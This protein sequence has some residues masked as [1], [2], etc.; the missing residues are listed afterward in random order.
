[1]PFVAVAED[2]RKYISYQLQP[3]QERQIWLCPHCGSRM[4]FVST[5]IRIKHFRHRTQS[6]ICASYEPETK[7]H[8]ELKKFGYEKFKSLGYSCNYEE[9]IG[10]RIADVTIKKGITLPIECQFSPL[11]VQEV[12][13]KVEDYEIA[14]VAR[15]LYILYAG[16]NFLRKEE[17]LKRVYRLRRVEVE[18]EGK[19]WWIYYDNHILRE[20]H[21]MPK[22]RRGYKDEWEEVD[23]FCSTLFLIKRSK[24]LSSSEIK[25]RI[26]SLLKGDNV[27]K[28][29]TWLDF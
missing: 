2:G 13:Q 12:E 5:E 21:F 15:P 4:S 28:H 24:R 25:F 8:L 29:P 3:V 14:G 7:E 22:F 9:K 19:E 20:L 18:F 10:N 23:K 16:V 26:E 27:G 11:A 6:G 17:S 1:M